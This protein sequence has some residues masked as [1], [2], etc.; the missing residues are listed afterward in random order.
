M[1]KAPAVGRVIRQAVQSP[2]DSFGTAPAPKGGRS[3]LRCHNDP[4]RNP[5]GAQQSVP[6][7]RFGIYAARSA[8]YRP[9]R[10]PA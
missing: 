8:C 9:L 2:G 3:R 7:A 10:V 6:A 4:V 1:R 5:I